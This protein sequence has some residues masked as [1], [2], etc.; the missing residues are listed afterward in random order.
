MVIIRQPNETKKSK[1]EKQTCFNDVRV[2][3][4]FVRDGMRKPNFIQ[5]H[6]T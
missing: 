1:R 5:D 4:R 6:K 2:A 3:I